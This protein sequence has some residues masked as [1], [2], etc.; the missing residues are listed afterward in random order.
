VIHLDANNLDSYPGTGQGSVLIPSGYVWHD[1]SSIQSLNFSN[2]INYNKIA[3]PILIADGGRSLFIQNGGFVRYI[4]V[5]TLYTLRS[6]QSIGTLA[7]WHI[8]TLA[9]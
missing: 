3:A 5:L 7:D 6:K 2:S 1:L 9:H 4:Y 8:S